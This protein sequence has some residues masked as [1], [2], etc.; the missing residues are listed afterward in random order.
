M[1]VDGGYIF[2]SGNPF[3]IG[4]NP[5]FAFPREA[6]N[7]RADSSVEEAQGTMPLAPLHFQLVAA[8]VNH[9][10]HLRFLKQITTH[11]YKEFVSLGVYK[12]S[13]RS[14]RLKLS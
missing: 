6:G 4:R 2:L 7:A 3:V 10:A 11:N 5:F 8:E 9:V 1:M 12:F 14:L 13:L